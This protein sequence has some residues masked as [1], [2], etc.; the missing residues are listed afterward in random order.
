MP[1]K[2]APPQRA[3]LTYRLYQALATVA[4]PL[5]YRKIAQKLKAANV[6]EGRCR[7]PLGYASQPR[8]GGQLMWC[9]AASVGESLSALTLIE[10]MGQRHPELN[11]LITS[12]T[13]TSAEVVAKRLP[14]RCQHQFAPL[15]SAPA[16]RRFFNHWQPDL[17]T[18]VESELWPQM[19][20]QAGK[21]APLTLLNARLSQGS[22][23]NWTRFEKTARL[24]LDQFDLIRTQDEQT[25]NGL[26]ALGAHSRSI[27]KGQNL[28]SAAG[29]LPVDTQALK[30]L[31]QQIGPRPVWVAA[32]THDGEEGH[33]LEAHKRLLQ[34]YPGLLLVLVPRHPERADH[35]EQMIANAG[36]RHSRRSR[37]E[38]PK[39]QVYLADTL[40]E[41][42]LFYNL[43]PLVFLG[44]S[45]VPVGGHNPFE[46]A[47]ASAVV[48][49]GPH[50]ANFSESYED[51]SSAGGAYTVNDSVSLARTLG[52]LINDPDLQRHQGQ[53]AK[54]FAN[55]Q[56]QGLDQLVAELS[57]LLK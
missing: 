57:A 13:P 5:V 11:F 1:A 3:T 18:F 48:M 38:A 14:A 27:A 10:A 19:I 41:M 20:M 31:Q 53:A 49:H 36:L 23:R 46:P 34:E 39:C 25:K 8:P 44:G 15:D 9:H 6:P 22:L 7:E 2:T 37:S 28:K 24:L 16:L 26:L 32:S 51:F 33:V 30:K 17:V 12:G 40:G 45:L 47:H 54:A 50:Y 29:P 42:G 43:S 56:M 4:A 55:S 35:I 21:L 52:M